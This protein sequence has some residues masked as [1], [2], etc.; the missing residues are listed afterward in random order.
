MNSGKVQI[1]K[2]YTRVSCAFDTG[3][4]GGAKQSFKQRCDVNRIVKNYERTGVI[5]HGVTAVGR[6]L[7]ISEN[8]DFQ[9]AMNVVIAA[10]D[11][12]AALSPELRRRFDN[13][14]AQFVAFVGDPANQQEAESLGLVDKPAPAEAPPA[15]PEPPEKPPAAE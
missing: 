1:R 13:D 10:Q 15:A 8:L 4:E 11:A 2:P 12:F 5:D 3:R 9:H 14:P 7:E 6:F